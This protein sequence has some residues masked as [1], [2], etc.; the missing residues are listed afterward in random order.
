MHRRRF[1]AAGAAAASVGLAG[2]RSLFQTRSARSPP[3]VED[4]PDAVYVPSHSEGMAMVDTADAGDYRVALTYARPHRFWLVNGDRTNKVEIGGEDSLHLMTT[5]WDPETGIVIP[6][7]AITATITG[8]G[9]SLASGKPLW[10]MLSQNMG[11]HAGDN[12]QLDGDGTYDIEVAVGPLSA[13]RTGAFR[14]RFS[15]RGTAS[16]TLEFEQ[17]AF[18]DLPFQRLPERQGDR[19][20]LDPMDMEMLP[21]SEAPAVADLPGTV[22]GEETSGDAVFAVTRLDSPPAGAT[23][24]ESG[25]DESTET[26]ADGDGSDDGDNGDRS[27]LAVSL[28]TP[29]NRYPV[30]MAALSATVTRDGNT[31]FEGALPSTVDTEL[32]YHYGALAAVQSGDEVTVSVDTPPQVARHEGYETAFF[33]F[34]DVSLTVD[35]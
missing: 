34:S 18:D 5:I 9:E 35:E 13:R 14:D 6:S 28:R 19:G 21:V 27:Y 31:V 1:L 10:P 7:G 30:P 11:V 33:E 2:C 26:A 15:E 24:S 4:R 17:S 16:F 20:A 25:D 29:H 32:G 22:I 3:L 12:L 23:D 8:G